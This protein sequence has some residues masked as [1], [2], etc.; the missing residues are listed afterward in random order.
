[1]A[2]N[3]L[4][5]RT[6]CLLLRPEFLEN[7]F[8]NL[9]DVFRTLGGASPA[10]PL[11]ALVAAALL[12]SHWELRMVDADVEPLTDE[13]F[14]WAD[15]VM[16]SGIYTGWRVALSQR[17]AD[18]VVQLVLRS[19][20]TNSDHDVEMCTT[21][22]SCWCDPLATPGTVPEFQVCGTDCDCAAGLS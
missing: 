19:G 2:T 20:A 17:S 1:M 11:G 4:T 9:T 5:G 7:T 22:A 15:I 13:H 8:Y 10:P 6:R 12:P 14:A 21:A 3:L 16:I 18:A